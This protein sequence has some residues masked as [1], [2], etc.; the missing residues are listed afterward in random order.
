MH[1]VQDYGQFGAFKEISDKKI[2]ENF[3]VNI[4]GMMNVIRAV[5]P[6]F[7]QQKSGHI[8]NFSSTAGFYGFP[9]SSI[10]VATK[11]AINGYSESLSGELKPLGINVT[12]VLPGNFRT[13]FLSQGSLNWEDLK[14]ITDYDSARQNQKKFLSASDWQQKG[15]PV[16]GMQVLIQAI[17]SDNPPIHLL[18]GSD[19]YQLA[20]KKIELVKDEL[21]T[22]RNKGTDTNF[23]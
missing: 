11:H 17:N 22:W 23:E 15:N 2:R 7:R 16:K 6:Y 4:F 20:D 12:C 19:A 13:D 21:A 9:L 8:V 3:E 5:L 18:L 14:N 1:S 10:Y